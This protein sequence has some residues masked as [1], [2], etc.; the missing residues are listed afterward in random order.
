MMIIIIVVIVI[1]IT[2]PAH[3]ELGTCGTFLASPML[4][5]LRICTR[6]TESGSTVLDRFLSKVLFWQSVCPV[7]AASVPASTCFDVAS[8]KMNK[9]L[10]IAT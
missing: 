2:L 5:V 10:Y 8:T 6:S 3:D 9:L 1:V 4:C 7:L